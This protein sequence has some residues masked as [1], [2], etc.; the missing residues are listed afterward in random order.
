KQGGPSSLILSWQ[1]PSEIEGP[2]IGYIIYYTNDV[3]LEE[4]QWAAQA[5]IGN[6][7]E[8]T[9]QRLNMN[10]TYYFK[11]RARFNMMFGP[12]SDIVQF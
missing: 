9:I 11:V 10:L 8:T 4:Q 7:T 2:I 12:I 5:I 6:I 1:P 3:G